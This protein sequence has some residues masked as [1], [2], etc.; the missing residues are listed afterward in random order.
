MQI[1][2]LA[3]QALPHLALVPTTPQRHPDHK[4]DQAQGR[5]QSHAPHFGGPGLTLLHTALD[6]LRG[7][8]LTQHRHA[9][10]FTHLVIDI[11]FASSVHRKLLGFF[12]FL[13]GSMPDRELSCLVFP[14][15]VLK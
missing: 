6:H 9:H 10:L 11:H 1:T 5:A 4:Q 2:E 14:P 12:F 8:H 3:H 15:F 7:V 13:S